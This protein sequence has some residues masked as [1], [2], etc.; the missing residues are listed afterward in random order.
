MSYYPELDSHIRNKVKV[1]KDLS[2]YDTKK[3]LNV[4]MVVDTSNIYIYIYI[5][6]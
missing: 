5:Y 1:V 6:M 4:A 2:N 3:E